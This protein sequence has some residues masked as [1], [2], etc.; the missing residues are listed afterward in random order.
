MDLPQNIRYKDVNYWN[1]RFSEEESYDWL[2]EYEDLRDILKENL[3]RQNKNPK[4]LQLGCG[5]SQ[6]SLDLYEDGY[7][8]ITNIDI[9][10]VLISKMKRKYP[11][12]NYEVMDMT[13]LD[14][15]DDSFDLVIEK[16]T[17]DALLVD[18]KS[19]WDLE[20]KGSKQVSQSLSQVKR[21]L[22]KDGVF[23]SITFSQPHFRVPLLAQSG[24]GW[25]IHV[26]KFT[27]T[28]GMLDYF[29]YVCQDGDP[30]PAVTKWCLSD[31]PSIVNNDSWSSS[32]EEDFIGKLDSSC[33]LSSSE[34]VTGYSDSIG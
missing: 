21:V 24:L 8:D 26:E 23:I 3:K 6:L 33:L 17:L 14:Y 18:S 2:A 30:A 4:I 22:K 19:P 27:S 1:E 13:K 16:A 25:N 10:Q 20:S 34:D 29:V 11:H 9:S 31:G 15:C 28:H 7:D 32:D 5:N 12:L